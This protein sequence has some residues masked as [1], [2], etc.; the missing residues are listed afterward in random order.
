MRMTT[1]A[2]PIYDKR[3]NS[4][5]M[6]VCVCVCARARVRVRVRVRAYERVRVRAYERVCVRV[7][8]EAG[9]GGWGGGICHGIKQSALH[10]L[11]SGKAFCVHVHI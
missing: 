6:C 5:W 10:A 2:V 1:A 11:A 4:R 9:E 7:A 3:N 8:V